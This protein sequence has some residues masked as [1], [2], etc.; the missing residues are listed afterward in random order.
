MS[1]PLPVIDRL[2][3]RLAAT[4]GAAWDRSLGNAPMV[5]VKT[6]WGEELTGFSD[7]LG[8]IAWA[9]EN[10]PERCPN[11]IEFRNL[12]RHAP[13]LDAPRI[14]QERKAATPERI[15]AELAKL[16]PAQPRQRGAVDVRWAQSIVAAHKRGVRVNSLPLRMARDALENVRRRSVEINWREAA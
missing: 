10:L 3:Q 12:C 13:L 14:E 5:D 9:L 2:F 8:L 1:L 15:A 4:Y 11:V 7:R 16:T 6:V